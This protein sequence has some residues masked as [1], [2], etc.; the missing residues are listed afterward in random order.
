MIIARKINAA[1]FLFAGSCQIE[2]K[3]GRTRAIQFLP[4]PN[5]DKNTSRHPNDCVFL[6]YSSKTRLPRPILN[7]SF[8][9]AYSSYLKRSSRQTQIAFPVASHSTLVSCEFR[10][11]SQVIPSQEPSTDWPQSV[12]ALKTFVFSFG[13]NK[14]VTF[15]A[16]VETLNLK[17]SPLP[18]SHVETATSGAVFRGS[19]PTNNSDRVETHPRA[20]RIRSF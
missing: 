17:D 2:T 16:S 7:P 3:P 9:Y 18:V 20:K 5:P 13:F 19:F 15:P 12:A 11:H 10:P 8:T 4:N 14:T 6:L 1:V